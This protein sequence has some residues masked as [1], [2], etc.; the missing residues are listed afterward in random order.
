M[1][2]RAGPG[3]AAGLPAQLVSPRV[4]SPPSAAALRPIATD[5]ALHRVREILDGCGTSNRNDLAIVAI[6]TLIEEG[7]NTGPAII[8]AAQ[9]RRV[10][11]QEL[12]L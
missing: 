5:A 4:C 12:R 6:K 10:D 3:G 7:V 1:A 8:G 9:R 2:G 11:V